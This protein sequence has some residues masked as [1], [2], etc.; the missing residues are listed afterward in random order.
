MWTL[1]TVVSHAGEEGVTMSSMAGLR[2]TIPSFIWCLSSH[3]NGKNTS[4]LFGLPFWSCHSCTY[5]LSKFKGTANWRKEHLGV[6][7]LLVLISLWKTLIPLPVG[8]TGSLSLGCNPKRHNLRGRNYKCLNP[9]RSK[10]WTW[11]GGVIQA[12]EHLSWNL[13][14]SN[15]SNNNKKKCRLAP[16]SLKSK[17][18]RDQNPKKKLAPVAPPIIQLLERL[19]SEGSWLEASLDK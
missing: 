13:L 12:V 10:S 19:R 15:P 7:V 2:G 1:A 18:L 9:E 17:V 4:N 11:T 16:K 3:V 14:S 8:G 5:L 6:I